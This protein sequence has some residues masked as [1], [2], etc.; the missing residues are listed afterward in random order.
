MCWRMEGSGSLAKATC[1]AYAYT[2][3]FHDA[4]CLVSG[5]VT[6]I[7]T[8]LHDCDLSKHRSAVLI[9][10]GLVVALLTGGQ[11]DG[12]QWTGGLLG[13]AGL[14]VLL[15]ALWSLRDRAPWLVIDESGLSYKEWGLPPVPWTNG[16][17][18]GGYTAVGPSPPSQPQ[19]IRLG[20]PLS[21]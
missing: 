10:A 4:G 1:N 18:Y 14:V 20:Q 15:H 6:F 11:G 13:G 21:S 9:L 7:A 8:F 5:L 16:V 2:R 17:R 19:P 12:T 3:I